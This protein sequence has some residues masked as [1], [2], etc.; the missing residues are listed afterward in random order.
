MMAKFGKCPLCP[1]DSPT[2]RIYGEGV[3]AHHLA[4]P[5]D[6]QSH[7]K[8]A[9]VA[10]EAHRGELLTKFFRDQAAAM[11]ACC[12]NCGKRLPRGDASNWAVRAC[13]CHIIP[14][15]HFE[16]VMIHPL[17]VWYGCQQCHH[18]YDDKGWTFAVTMRVWP[19]VVDRFKQFMELIKDTEL[20]HL[21][22]ALRI[23][24]PTH[25]L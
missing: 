18:D 23:L 25:K 15:R 19:V 8:R 10:V 9:K 1:K 4:N 3:C 2:V 13:I 20:R 12:E 21:P 11:P 6:D 16:S 5:G 7:E 14:K 17:N 22:D 24:M